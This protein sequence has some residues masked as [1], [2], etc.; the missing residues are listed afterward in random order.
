MDESG[1]RVVAVVRSRQEFLERELFPIEYINP[2]NRRT[3]WWIIFKTPGESRD[4]FRAVVEHE[5]RQ[6]S[7]WEKADLDSIL[8]DFI[9]VM[10]SIY[11]DLS[12]GEKG[13]HKEV[14]PTILKEIEVNDNVRPKLFKIMGIQHEK[15]NIAALKAISKQLVMK[16][17]SNRNPGNLTF[18]FK[19]RAGN[20]SGYFF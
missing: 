19:S 12:E 20:L 3:R 10:C 16:G 18:H 14:D 8:G 1:H 5:Y 2:M 17:S 6:Y 11:P 15:K 9:D 4:E 13:P 7:H